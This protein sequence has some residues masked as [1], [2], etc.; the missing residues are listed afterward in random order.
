MCGTPKASRRIRADRLPD[1]I[2]SSVISDG[3]SA[4][5]MRADLKWPLPSKLGCITA[6]VMLRPSGVSRS[7]ISAW[8]GLAGRQDFELWLGGCAR[9]HQRQRGQ[10]QGGGAADHPFSPPISGAGTY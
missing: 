1:V 9:G 6:G 4:G 7:Y 3:S 10:G 8:V 5:S 2:V